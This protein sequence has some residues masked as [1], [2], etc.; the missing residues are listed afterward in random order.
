MSDRGFLF[1]FS[2]VMIIGGLGAAGWLIASGQA[3]TVDGLFL[4]L[5]ASL[6]ALVFALYVKYMIGRAMEQAATM[7]TAA[8]HPAKAPSAKTAPVQG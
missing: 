2:V 1:L 3:G 5:V 6:V 8:E 4:V 7:S